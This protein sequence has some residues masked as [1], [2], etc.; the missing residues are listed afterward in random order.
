MDAFSKKADTQHAEAMKNM[1]DNTTYT[2]NATRQAIELSEGRINKHTDEVGE[3]VKQH[4]TKERKTAVRQVGAEINNAVD[5]INNH[6][7]EKVDDLRARLVGN[8]GQI[9]Y[10]E[11]TEEYYVDHEIGGA[12]GEA[13]EGLKKTVETE[14]ALTRTQVMMTGDKV[15]KN[16][17]DHTDE[18]HQTTQRLQS[19]RAEV[20]EILK[21][22]NLDDDD[23]RAL[24]NEATAIL[25]SRKLSNTQK[26]ILLE[27]MAQHINDVS[28]ISDGD[29][30]RIA[31]ARQ[32]F[33][34]GKDLIV[35]DVSMGNNT[36]KFIDYDAIE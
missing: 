15:I 24:G 31:K 1:D 23:V 35:K 13:T 21:E 16:V 17:N 20:T 11:E 3:G 28:Y 22:C 25:N 36:F 8:Y 4:V 29:L 26:I 34:A 18:A 14:H 5:K 7:D 12:L 6:T 32:M 33:E 9:E 19:A 2:V 27:S 10:N 30:S